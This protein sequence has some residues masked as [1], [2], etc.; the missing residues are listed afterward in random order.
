M[1]ARHALAIDQGG[2]F[3]DIIAAPLDGGLARIA[4][5]PRAEVPDLAAAT[6]TGRVVIHATASAAAEQ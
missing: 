6:F 5:R 4:K 3:L 2:S 1:T